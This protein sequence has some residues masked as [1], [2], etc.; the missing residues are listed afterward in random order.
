MISNVWK[1]EQDLKDEEILKQFPV[2]VRDLLES[3]LQEGF[4][5][6]LVGGAVRDFF[7]HGH[8]SK[9]LDFELRHPYEYDEKD[10]GFR[11]GRLEERLQD[12]YGHK[13]ELLS[14]SIMRVHWD[15]HEE[16]VELAPARIESYENSDGHGHSDME[17]RLVSNGDYRDTFARRDFTLNAMGIEFYK[18]ETELLIRFIDPFGGREDLNSRELVPCGENF[19]RDPV[20]FC[21]AVRFALKFN[22]EFSSE[23]IS[24]MGEFNLSALTSFYF[25]REGLK[26]DF[27]RF[28]EIFYHWIM[29]ANIPLSDELKQLS[30][31]GGIGSPNLNLTTTHE[32]L[33]FLIYHKTKD[34]AEVA[35]KDIEHF[36]KVAKLKSALVDGHLNLKAAL[37]E[38]G[39][40]EVHEIKEQLKGLSFQEFLAYPH[41]S[42]LKRFHMSVGRYGG[43]EELFL[44]GRINSHLYSVLLKYSK[45]LPENL[46][47]KEGFQKM[48]DQQSIAP[49]QRSDALYYCHFMAVC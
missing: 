41:K 23:L 36:S 24:R 8:F 6:T 39:S 19:T 42:A 14:F 35:F 20:R 25:F 21:R 49:V 9:D 26:V 11:L 18:K 4:I 15:E 5:L 48:V 17:V 44:L 40:I 1:H 31:L 37:E 16:D 47:G 3:I 10:W 38:L 34:G 43:A 13:V 29:K 32:V 46:A 45:L 28:T 33:L 12:T 7:I 27:F 30:F 22:L 2:H